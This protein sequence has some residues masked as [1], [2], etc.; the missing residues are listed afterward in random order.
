[1]PTEVDSSV[2]SALRWLKHQWRERADLYTDGTDQFDKSFRVYWLPEE[3]DSALLH[4]ES[5]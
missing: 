4:I 1:M 3:A 2:F 5:F